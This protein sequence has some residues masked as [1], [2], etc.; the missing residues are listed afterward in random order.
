[1][2]GGDGDGD[3]DGVL[4]SPHD[5]LPPHRGV[6]CLG[7]G[8]ALRLERARHKY[9]L[10][11]LA[12]TVVGSPGPM[13]GGEDAHVARELQV[14]TRIVGGVPTGVQEFEWLV[15]LRDTRFGQEGFC[16]GTLVTAVCELIADKLTAAHCMIDTTKRRS[17]RS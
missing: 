3:G 8:L 2:G 15:N 7:G 11:A 1:M 10:C 6:D 16:G 4:S 9:M 13:P 17:A 5:A 14:G 12:A